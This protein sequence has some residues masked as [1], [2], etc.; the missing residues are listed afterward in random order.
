[1]ENINLSQDEINELKSIQDQTNQLIVSFGQIELGIQT[2]EIQKNELKSKLI[3]LKIKEDQ[4]G[5]T[6]QSKY[7][8]GSINIETGEF[9]K[10]G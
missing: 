3:E 5:Q 8:N 9:I 10:A 4:L 2:L 6:L 7:G 1:M